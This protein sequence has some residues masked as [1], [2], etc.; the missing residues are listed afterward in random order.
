MGFVGAVQLEYCAGFDI[1]VW[2]AIFSSFFRCLIFLQGNSHANI[3]TI[4]V[5]IGTPTDKPTTA[6]RL[7]PGLDPLLSSSV[8]VEEDVFEDGAVELGLDV[9]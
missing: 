6:L 7:R 8:L 4:R 2:F 3:A 9:G 5:A 1:D